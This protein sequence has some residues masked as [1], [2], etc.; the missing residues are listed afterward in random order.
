MKFP[1]INR[2]IQPKASCFSLLYDDVREKC[3]LFVSWVASLYCL[4]CPT[5]FRGASLCKEIFKKISPPKIGFTRCRALL[6]FE[7]FEG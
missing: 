1:G 4:G 6:D 3:V 2:G 7:D 5:L